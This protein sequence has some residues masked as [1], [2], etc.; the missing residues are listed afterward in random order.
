MS[1]VSSINEKYKLTI[2]EKPEFITEFTELAQPI[3][4]SLFD[5]SIDLDAPLSLSNS[6]VSLPTDHYP[7]DSSQINIDHW[8]DSQQ[9]II[10]FNNQDIMSDL[11]GPI[12]SSHIGDIT[13]NN[14]NETNEINIECL[15]IKQ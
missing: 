5:M 12:I 13:S 9:L 3:N 8:T 14:T 6:L 7:I 2:L 1:L 4:I 15:H 10:S 11:N